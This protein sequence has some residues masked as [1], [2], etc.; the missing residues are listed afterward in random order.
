MPI[1]QLKVDEVLA[2]LHSG[3]EGAAEADAGRRL[4]ESGPNQV[5]QFAG[6]RAEPFAAL[7]P[8]SVTEDDACR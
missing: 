2:S 4:T 6:G 8:D 5:D 7:T 3:P 1:H